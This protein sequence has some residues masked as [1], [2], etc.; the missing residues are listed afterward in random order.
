MTLEWIVQKIRNLG[1]LLLGLWL[2]ASCSTPES[3]QEGS[4]THFLQSC[5]TTC[6]DG[7]QCIC[8]VCT[9]SCSEQNDCANWAG[10]ASCAPLGPRVVEQRCAASELTAICDAACLTDVDCSKLAADHVCDYGYC[11]ELRQQPPPAAACMPPK[12]ASTDVLILGDVLIELTIYAQQLEQAA[13]LSGN[14]SS[15]QHYRN[16]AAAA[17]SLL[18][19]GPQSI[20]SEYTSALDAGPARVIIMDG[21]ATDVLNGQCAGMLTP[22][23]AAAR[24]AVNGAEALFQR[25]A[26]DGVEHV[27]YFFYGDP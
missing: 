9:R 12:L 25:F 8:G 4:E 7:M 16:Q 19:T 11:R 5:D 20:E 6:G 15:G 23:C 10:V 21:G 26:Q 17:S 27:V 1:P 3:S 13:V 22:D 24:A 2:I 18:A 14:L